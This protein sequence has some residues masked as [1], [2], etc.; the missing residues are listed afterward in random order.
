MSNSKRALSIISLIVALF[1]LFNEKN[2]VPN[3]QNQLSAV[4]QTQ[5]DTQVDTQDVVATTTNVFIQT[6]DMYVVSRVVDGDTIE[7]AKEGVKEKVRLIG[8]NTPET[9]DPRKKVECFG[10]EASAELKEILLGQKVRLVSDDTQDV[11]DRY[12]RLL[13]YVY[14]ED[15][16]FVNQHMIAEGYGYEYTYKVP[17]LFQKEFKEAQLSAQIQQK[18]L[19]K[20]GVCA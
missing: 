11:Q 6:Q 4:A 15:G 9:V 19:W 18:G 17:Y 8:V 20:E 5:V 16:L 3:S 12:G 10:K 13:A 7:V 14:R 2:T 1:V